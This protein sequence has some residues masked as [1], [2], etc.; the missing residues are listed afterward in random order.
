M[1]VCAF[2]YYNKR[3]RQVKVEKSTSDEC[4]LTCCDPYKCHTDIHTVALY[5]YI[6]YILYVEVSLSFK[7]FSPSVYCQ[8]G[9]VVLRAH[10]SKGKVI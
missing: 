9:E 7:F 10:D 6:L 8:W 4:E 2:F 3:Q 1:Y 5:I